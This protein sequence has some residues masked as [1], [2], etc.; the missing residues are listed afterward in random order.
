MCEEAEVA[1]GQ[2]ASREKSQQHEEE[3]IFISLG[4]AALYSSVVLCKVTSGVRK[5]CA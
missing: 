3:L 1:G 5:S 4:S 2:E